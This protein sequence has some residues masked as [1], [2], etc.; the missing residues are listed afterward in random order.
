MTLEE[1]NRSD[2]VAHLRS[3]LLGSVDSEDELS[4]IESRL[5]VDDEFLEELE[6]QEDELIEDYLHDQLTP[7]ERQRFETHFLISKERRDKLTFARAFDAHLRMAKGNEGHRSRK[8]SRWALLEP[9]FSPVPVAAVL[10]TGAL[11]FGA[12]WF[13]ISKR[14]M[15][16]EGLVALNKA[17]S[18]ERSVE[19]RIA[20]FD[21][22][23]YYKVRGDVAP[24]VDTDELERAELVLRRNASDHPTPENREALGRLHIAKRQFDE[25]LSQLEAV[26][27]TGPPTAKLLNDL[28]VAYLEKFNSS[29]TK[30]DEKTAG[31]ARTALENFDG[32]IRLDPG[33]LEARYNL[34]LCLEALNL[35]NQARDAWQKYL[36]LDQNSKWSDEARGHLQRLGADGSSERSASE[37]EQAFLSAFREQNTEKGFELASENRELIREKY[38]PQRLAFSIVSA[39][40]MARIEGLAALS[41]LAE[42]EKS[43]NKDMFAADLQA[44]YSKATPRQIEILRNAQYSIKRGYYFCLE[45]ND[46]EEAKTQFGVARSLFLKAGDVIEAETVAK[47]FIAYCLY[48]LDER[49]SS[50]ELLNEIGDFTERRSYKWFS[51]MNHYWWLGSQESLGF[52]SITETRIEYENALTEAED[53]QDAYMTQKFLLSLILK[54]SFVKQETKATAYAQRLL[55]FSNRPGS[56]SRQK[57]R[58]FDKIISVGIATKSPAFSKALVLESVAVAE[59]IDDPSFRIAAEL[60]AGIIHTEAG[61]FREA[62]RWLTTARVH[63]EALP[64]EPSRRGN[65][66]RILLSFGHME[67]KRGDLHRAVDRYRQAL[68]ISVEMR[69][70]LLLYEIRKSL[71]LAYHD[72][73]DDSALDK[74]V[75]PTI[76]L[77]EDYR[78]RIRDE[79]ERNTFFDSEQEVYDVA[80]DHELRMD[81]TDVAFNY[82]ERSNSRSLLDWLSERATVVGNDQHQAILFDKPSAPLDLRGIQENLPDSAQILQYRILDDKL[83]IWLIS[84]DEFFTYS[85]DVGADRINELARDFV[86]GVHDK[87]GDQQERAKE[88]SRTLYRILI[89]PAA[90]NLDGTKQL[91]IIANRILFYVPFA[92]L[93]SEEG[94][95]LIQ[96]F[97]ISYSPSANVF[98]RCSRNAATKKH[99]V[100]E[101]LLSVG[102]PSFDGRRFAGLPDLPESLDEAKG[103]AANYSGSKLLFSHEATPKAFQAAIPDFNVIH[104]AGHYVVEPDSPLS[105][106]LIMAAGEGGQSTLTAGE[107][108]RYELP[109]TKLV[110]LSACQSAVEGYFAGEGPVGLTRTFLAMGVPLVVASSWAVDSNATHDLMLSFHFRRRHEGL[111]TVEALRRSQLEFINNSNS[112]LREPYYWA[113]FAAFGGYADY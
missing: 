19:S 58:N 9:F 111:T 14:P 17:Y 1:P 22:A 103:I 15:D 24:K 20:E 31:L 79:E 46:F 16:R 43:R 63:A 40:A 88:I 57:V 41:F 91:C 66:A 12:T 38:L 86:N 68:N 75:T 30:Y 45:K 108:I 83:V 78:T 100:Q 81:R 3:Y 35:P 60:N 90:A 44:I 109:E 87:D 56:S 72:L 54:S 61:D 50:A 71:I 13:L 5:I 33:N 62:E 39:D 85:S 67:R 105:S 27:Q 93:L 55:A 47:Y 77:A 99:L 52:K 110:V 104:F 82:A 112:M 106:K 7:T 84:R 21:Y 89:R 8:S 101:N 95:Y 26:R 2:E 102:N 107:L 11:V 97:A 98:F 80:I 76:E 69:T 92:A 94:R 48:N 64:D 74:E 32:A 113:A 10:I 49:R 70:P 37:Q 29:P 42:I 73:R 59:T 18:S 25:A 53:L 51:L 96:D 23:P 6:F 34:G 36:E 28:G 4:A 65:L